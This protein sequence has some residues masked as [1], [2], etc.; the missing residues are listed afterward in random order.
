MFDRHS[1]T[2][3]HV[4]VD[5]TKLVD[6]PIDYL[7]DGLKEYSDSQ[8]NEIE[9]YARSNMKLQSVGYIKTGGRLESTEHQYLMK[10]GDH[11][12]IPTTVID[13][14]AKERERRKNG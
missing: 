6:G 13:A 7:F 9:N 5:M 8:L 1:V 12:Y 3:K 10:L 2:E 11:N 4:E 14:I